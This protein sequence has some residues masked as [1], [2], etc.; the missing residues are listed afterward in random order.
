M[1]CHPVSILHAP[2]LQD[3]QLSS[4]QLTALHQQLAAAQTEVSAAEQVRQQLSQ[5]AAL[6][7]TGSQTTEDSCGD[8]LEIG[9]CKC[10]QFGCISR[11]H[12]GGYHTI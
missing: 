3:A 9:V 10:T 1:S 6:A 5:K 11:K 4:E 2:V 8:S 12:V 7:S